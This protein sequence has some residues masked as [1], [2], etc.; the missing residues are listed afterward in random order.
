MFVPHQLLP[1][2][3]SRN[4]YLIGD[5]HHNGNRRIVPNVV[6]IIVS[7]QIYRYSVFR[8][9]T[10]QDPT[11]RDTCARRHSRPYKDTLAFNAATISRHNNY[12][13]TRK[14]W[15]G[16]NGFKPLQM[17]VVPCTTLTFSNSTFCP[18]TVFIFLCGS[19]NKQR[20]FHC[21]ALTGWLS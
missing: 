8:L 19:Q 4:A 2:R 18:Q 16:T 13:I 9:C 12:K 17:S 14:E 20:L 3:N 21:T 5:D 7:S 1:L 15:C 10:K 6:C 11:W